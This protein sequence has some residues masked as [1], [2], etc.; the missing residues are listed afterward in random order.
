MTRQVS[1]RILLPLLITIRLPNN[2]EKGEKKGEEGTLFARWSV[3]HGRKN[4]GITLP[5]S[6]LRF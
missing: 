2:A 4:D 1:Q 3:V 5:R 6:N